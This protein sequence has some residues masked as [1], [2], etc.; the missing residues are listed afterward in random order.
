MRAA[1]IDR[2]ELRSLLR[3]ASGRRHIRGK[4]HRFARRDALMLELVAVAGLTV[5]ELLALRV[6]DLPPDS[7]DPTLTVEAR[8]L[9]SRPE[10]PWRL[11]Q[12]LWGYVTRL[13]L[14]LEDRLFPINVRRA[15]AVFRTHAARAGLAPVHT[16]DSLRRHRNAQMVASRTTWPQYQDGPSISRSA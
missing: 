6:R 8:A 4:P 11:G 2:L 13:E 14:R 16:L 9:D 3:T 7:T 5:H 1:P 10:I 15:R 12:R